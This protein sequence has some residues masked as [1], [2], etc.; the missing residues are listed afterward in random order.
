MTPAQ[1]KHITLSLFRTRCVILEGSEVTIGD[2]KLAEL[3]GVRHMPLPADYSHVGKV[4]VA[5]TYITKAAVSL[6]ETCLSLRELVAILKPFFMPDIVYLHSIT[7]RRN[8][9]HWVIYVRG[10]RSYRT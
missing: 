8:L 4:I 3:L 7:L 5:R 2:A 1:A 9:W 6:T 10:V